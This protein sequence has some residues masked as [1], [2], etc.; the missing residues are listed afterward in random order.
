[1]SHADIQFYLERERRMREEQ[2]RE[3]RRRLQQMLSNLHSNCSQ[4]RDLIQK[5]LNRIDN[6]KNRAQNSGITQIEDLTTS[7]L[8]AIL[9]NIQ[10]LDNLNGAPTDYSEKQLKSQLRKVGEVME[11]IKRQS[12][13]VNQVEN[14][15][16]KCVSTI[17][18]IRKQQQRI[19]QQFSISQHS[20]NEIKNLQSN[21]GVGE[22]KSLDKLENRFNE[23]RQDL[24]Q[25]NNLSLNSSQVKYL[26]DIANKYQK[27]SDKIA[28][29]DE[30][31]TAVTQ[32]IKNSYSDRLS[33]E[34]AQL[35]EKIR[36]DEQK[37][38]QQQVTKEQVKEQHNEELERRKLEEK[39]LKILSSARQHLN[40][41]LQEP[42]ISSKI[43]EEIENLEKKFEQVM[44]KP[45]IDLSSFYSISMLPRIKELKQQ[46][47]DHQDLAERYN[48]LYSEYFVLATEMK[49]DPLQFELDEA[50]LP[51]I[52]IQIQ[53]LSELIAKQ[54]EQRMFSTAIMAS[55]EELGYEVIGQEQA[56]TVPDDVYSSVLYQDS[57]G[58]ALNVV[59]RTDGTCSTEYGLLSL[60]D[61]ELTYDEK[62]KLATETKSYCNQHKKLMEKLKDLGIDITFNSRMAPTPENAVAIN[63]SN[64]NVDDKIIQQLHRQQ[65]AT[66]SAARENRQ[67]YM[68]NDQS[69]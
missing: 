13:H 37:R 69:N 44:E 48:K 67:M 66:Q 19:A 12:D 46:I 62:R 60:E 4:C 57:Y 5:Y 63:A 53:R 64:F 61:R 65:Q 10:Q 38:Q 2:K 1:M 35:M 30:N 32:E 52:K 59:T 49:E 58:N 42:F 29:E 43:S 24:V 16:V 22:I 15:I 7:E 8:N 27:L 56:D 36:A 45:E 55:L 6:I 17:N 41:L 54:D 68:D 34:I 39:R 3:R 50:S 31:F 20:L 18:Q 9:D 51:L 47:K 11:Q 40:E 26:E 23:Y 25:N 14:R 28:S 21:Y 33:G